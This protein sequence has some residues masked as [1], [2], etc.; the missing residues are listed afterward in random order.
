MEAPWDLFMFYAI[1]YD[2]DGTSRPYDEGTFNF[3]WSVFLLV[4]NVANT[5]LVV[6]LHL[7]FNKRTDAHGKEWEGLTLGRFRWGL[8]DTLVFSTKFN[9]AW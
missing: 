7:W 5:Y 9:L 8:T 6:M 4:R 3:R 2:N 1:K